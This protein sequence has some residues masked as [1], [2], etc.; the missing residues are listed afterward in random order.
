METFEKDSLIKG[1]RI[2]SGHV[3]V[4]IDTGDGF[5]KYEPVRGI[6]SGDKYHIRNREY[7]EYGRGIDFSELYAKENGAY[8]KKK[9][10][11]DSLKK[12]RKARDSLSG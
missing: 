10:K 1:E 9:I 12:L 8:K 11:L 7:V 6:V 4:D 3:F 5:Q 2:V